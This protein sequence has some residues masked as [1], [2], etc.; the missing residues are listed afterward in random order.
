MNEHR[1]ETDNCFIK[2]LYDKA[3]PYIQLGGY[4]VMLGTILGGLYIGFSFVATANANTTAVADLQTFKS[5]TQIAIASMQQEIHD[6]HEYL[7]PK[8]RDQ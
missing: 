8:G 3:T 4:L 1:R 6:L 7:I 5:D 2:S